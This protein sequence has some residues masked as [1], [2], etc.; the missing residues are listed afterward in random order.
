L[1]LDQKAIEIAE[2]EAR[3]AK[4]RVHT[5]EGDDKGLTPASHSESAV[6]PT[7]PESPYGPDEIEPDSLALGGSAAESDPPSESISKGSRDS[8]TLQGRTYMTS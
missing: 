7:A 8:P 4:Q 2:A 1:D 6:E 3:A 5:D